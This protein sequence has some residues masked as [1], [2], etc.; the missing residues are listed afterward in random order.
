MKKGDVILESVREGV[1]RCLGACDGELPADSIGD[2]IC[3]KS[4]KIFVR[5]REFNHSGSAFK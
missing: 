1:E 3:E 2:V 5:L 4:R